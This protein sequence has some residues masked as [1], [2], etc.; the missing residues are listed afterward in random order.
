MPSAL[1]QI[2]QK[3]AAVLRLELHENKEIEN[4]RDSKKNGNALGRAQRLVAKRPADRSARR[5]VVQTGRL[6]IFG[7]RE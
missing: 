7:N 2:Q 1:E 3:C 6:W 5:E 4:F